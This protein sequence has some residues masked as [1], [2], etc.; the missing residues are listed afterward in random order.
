M[1]H[2]L[3]ET[4]LKAFWC[5]ILAAFVFLLPCH[6]FA[7]PSALGWQVQPEEVLDAMGHYF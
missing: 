6:Q 1:L 3:I 4:L 5:W 2:S 7:S